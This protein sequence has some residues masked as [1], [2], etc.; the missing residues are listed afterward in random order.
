MDDMSFLAVSKK[1]LL[2][3]V[4]KLTMELNKLGF[5]LNSKTKFEVIEDVSYF[6]DKGKFA[7]YS[8]RK[9][10]SRILIV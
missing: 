7:I 4:E 6:Q 10:N 3:C 9:T 8:A 5:N 1:D 2:M